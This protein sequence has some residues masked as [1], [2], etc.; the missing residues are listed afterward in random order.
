MLTLPALLEGKVAL[1]EALPEPGLS[2]VSGITLKCRQ[3]SR[4]LPVLLPRQ[5]CLSPTRRQARRTAARFALGLA[6]ASSI[7]SPHIACS[8]IGTDLYAGTWLPTAWCH[9]GTS[10]VSSGK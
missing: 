2:R 4:S 6:K 1:R 5:A 10:G 3:A 8:R 7:A 9:S